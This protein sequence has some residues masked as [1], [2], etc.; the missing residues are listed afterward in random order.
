M[1][2]S[3][4]TQFDGKEI[5]GEVCVVGAGL[6]GTMI[7]ALLA[8]AGFQ[9]CIYEK[10]QDPRSELDTVPSNVSHPSSASPP[11]SLPSSSTIAN[12]I[13]SKSSVFGASTSATKRSI[14]LALSHRG[15]CALKEVGLLDTIMQ[16]AIKMPCRIIHNKYTNEVIKQPYGR[17]DEAIWSVGRQTINMTLLELLESPTF[18]GQVK[19]FFNH[20]LISADKDGSCVFSTIANSSS[21]YKFSRKFQL[22][23]GADGAY[24]SL[25]D[26]MCKQSRLNYSRSYVAH[27]Y[28]ELTI[29]PNSQGNYALTDVEGL[30]IWPRG[31]KMLIALPNPD[32]SFTATLFAPYKGKDGFDSID[33]NNEESILE[34]FRLH[35]PDIINLMPQLTSDYRNNPVGALVTVRVKPWNLGRLVLLGDAAHAVV[36]FYGQGMNAA[37][38]D[39]LIFYELLKK[40][41]ETAAPSSANNRIDF[42]TL[43]ERFSHL[44]QPST[45]GLA[46]LCIEHYH[47][48][49]SHTSSF[50]Y[51]LGKRVESALE[52]IFPS[53]FTSLYRL[54]AFSRTPYHEAIIR[55]NQ[56]R[57]YIYGFFMTGFHL[58]L[59]ASFSYK[60]RQKILTLGFMQD[61]KNIFFTF[62]K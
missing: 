15:M 47:D 60:C 49:A 61:L 16:Y 56:Q 4:D 34:Y 33:P 42:A 11:S 7:A 58:A 26:V 57:R 14:N 51:L 38:E 53:I 20:S 35:F 1:S 9:V 17:G 28:K 13:E 23:I 25:R 29:P 48:M 40:E 30:H 59:I 54:V 46:E 43:C 44:R 21:A 50:I 2:I 41:M 52:S 10:R 8:K 62:K 32:K 22:V 6:A 31:D 36:P 19:I 18:R 12:P 55:V 5:N 24:S 27:G 45:D 37:F 3:D 39:A